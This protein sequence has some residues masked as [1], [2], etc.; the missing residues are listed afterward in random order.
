[1][2]A[3]PSVTSGKARRSEADTVWVACWLDGCWRPG[4]WEFCYEN[5]YLC[6]SLQLN[7]DRW[8]VIEGTSIC[9]SDRGSL[10]LCPQYLIVLGIVAMFRLGARAFMRIAKSPGPW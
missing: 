10:V 7:N 2:F 3:F 6:C 1:M 5:V 4:C 9:G 8:C